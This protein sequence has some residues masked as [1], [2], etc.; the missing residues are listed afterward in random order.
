MFPYLVALSPIIFVLTTQLI[1]YI[2]TKSEAK[3]G[4]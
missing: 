1:I 4:N 3:K 2:V